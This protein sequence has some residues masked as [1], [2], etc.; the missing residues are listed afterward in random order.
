MTTWQVQTAKQRFSEVVRAAEAGDPQFIT[1]HGRPVAVLVDID[2]YQRTHRERPSFTS[3]LLAGIDAEGLEIPARLI[4]PER[5]P[6][7]FE[8][9]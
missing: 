9:E 2:E 6:D 5:N 8:S 7:L 1:K 3:F 4:D